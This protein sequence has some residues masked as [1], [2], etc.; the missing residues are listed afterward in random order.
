MNQL[1]VFVVGYHAAELP[2][3]ACMTPSLAAGNVLGAAPP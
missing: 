1:R 2:D 3:I